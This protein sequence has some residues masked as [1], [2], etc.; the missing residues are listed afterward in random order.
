MDFFA[1]GDMRG[2]RK[3]ALRERKS[4]DQVIGVNDRVIAGPRCWVT[5]GLHLVTP[6]SPRRYAGSGPH[7]I[8]QAMQR[9]A[10][11]V[12]PRTRDAAGNIAG[13]GDGR[14]VVRRCNIRLTFAD[15]AQAVRRTATSR[16]ANCQKTERLA[17]DATTLPSCSR[18]QHQGKRPC[19]AWPFRFAVVQCSAHRVSR[20]RRE[21]DAS[22]DQRV[23]T[24]AA[25]LYPHCAPR[26][27]HRAAAL[28]SRRT[29]CDRARP[30]G[31]PTPAA[32]HRGAAP[33]RP[34]GRDIPR[35]G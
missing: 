28:T 24:P 29:R 18:V 4:P 11:D 16:A 32:S 2:R 30:T 13:P 12:R 33:R 25:A 15:A 22:T 27:V 3:H 9:H 7:R 35:P 6:L 34:G 26:G 17:A 21:Q 5:S 1:P 14:S 20:P 31:R 10:A 8:A 19:A 23:P